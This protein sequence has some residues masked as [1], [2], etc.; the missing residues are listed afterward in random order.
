[1]RLASNN[2]IDIEPKNAKPTAIAVM[3]ICEG[4][5]ELCSDLP[6]P[7][8]NLKVFLKYDTV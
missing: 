8:S 5:T 2:S 7:I 1:M 3:R 4:V 6:T